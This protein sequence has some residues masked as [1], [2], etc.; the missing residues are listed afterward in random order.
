MHAPPADDPLLRFL[1]AYGRAYLG[2]GGPTSRLEDDVMSL[3]RAQG[4]ATECFAT[5]TGLFVTCQVEGG[6]PRTALTRIRTASLHLGRLC[7]LERLYQALLQGRVPI[8]QALDELEKIGAHSEYH[9]LVQ[10]AAAFV[11]GAAVSFEGYRHPVAALV[12]GGL[13][14]LTWL[15]TGGL[16]RRIRSATFK[17]FLGAFVA[18]FA[19]AA[20]RP[21]IPLP[22]EAF[23]TGSLLM[24]VPGLMLTTAIAELA[25][26]NLVSGTAKLM[27]ALLTLLALG[28][29]LLLVQ[30]LIHA[31][32]WPSLLK[33]PRAKAHPGSG[34]AGLSAAV[35]LTGFGVLFQ[36]PLRY[37]IGAP[38]VGMLGWLPVT[39]LGPSRL[40]VA[41]PLIGSFA[42]GSA[43]LILAQLLR[44]PSQLF[45]VPGILTLLPGMLAFIS[46]RSFALGE[47]GA[48]TERGFQVVVSA[49]SVVFGLAVARIFDWRRGEGA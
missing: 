15:L 39:Y 26:R 21:L 33:L 23:S 14:V 30:E 12:S 41:A 2:C 36:V 7:A 27:Q 32:G 38:V 8:T 18:L 35:S 28:L 31:L 45:T 16:L 20:L 42:V 11:A 1:L 48:G 3:G 34:W 13:T 46:F 43:G 17:E 25:D 47:L 44:I 6:P 22:A 9:P 37:L 10:V 24:L 29:A 49:I 40:G 4:Q 5:P 19:A